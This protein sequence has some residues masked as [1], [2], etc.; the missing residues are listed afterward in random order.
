M[1][2]TINSVLGDIVVYTVIYSLV[3]LGIVIAG[4]TGVFIIAGEGVMLTATSVG[5]MGA[6]FSGSWV[7]GFLAGAA[8][9]ALFGLIFAFFHEQVRVNQFI[10]GIFIVI[11]GTGLSN[12][13]YK[14][15]MGVRLS[16]PQAPPVPVVSIPGISRVPI[17]SALL[18][19][20]PLVYFVYV[21]TAFFYWFYYRTKIGLETRAIGENPQAADVV[22]VNVR[23]RRYIFA[24][25]A[26]ALMGLAGAYLPLVV[27]GTYNPN[28]SGGRGFMSIGIAIFASWKPHRALLGGFIFAAVEVI[29]FHLQLAAH[30]VPFQFFVML[31]FIVVLVIM[32]IFRR[33]I[34]YPAAIGKPYSRE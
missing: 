15:V 8:V 11:L 17:L 34:E 13:L 12:L 1:I 27:T 31:P 24:I 23:R 26:M 5:F 22:G 7:V 32:V 10:L 29:A 2:Q 19:Q 14:L 20:N 28:M 25:I 9:G 4:R 33:S 21:A 6:Y 16:A 3:S 18:D 30:A